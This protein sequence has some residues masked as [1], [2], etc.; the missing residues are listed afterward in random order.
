M[1]NLFARFGVV[2]IKLLTVWDGMDIIRCCSLCGTIN[3]AF[4][5]R[6]SSSFCFCFFFLFP[7]ANLPLV[8]I[9][10]VEGLVDALMILLLTFVCFLLFRLRDQWMTCVVLPYNT[11]ASLSFHKR[12]SPNKILHAIVTFHSEWSYHKARGNQTPLKIK[13]K[14]SMITF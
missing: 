6:T 4:D 8:Y 13:T 5:F 3:P 1:C 9:V 14:L 7:I 2:I 12:T 11:A 10:L